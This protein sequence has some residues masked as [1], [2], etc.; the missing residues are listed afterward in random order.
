VREE[1]TH[2]EETGYLRALVP[3]E[4]EPR[5]RRELAHDG[6]DAVTRSS[7]VCRPGKWISL[8]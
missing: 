5:G 3:G 8:M 6:A 7:T 1:H 2:G 4:G